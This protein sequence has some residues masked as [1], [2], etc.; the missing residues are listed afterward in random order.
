VF[1]RAGWQVG[2]RYLTALFPFLLPLVAVAL[3]AWRADARKLGLAGGAIGIGV[4]VYAVSAATLP[5]W[6]DLYQDP[7]YEVAFRL[8]G[9]GAA[10]PSLG[11]ALGLPRIVAI[12]PWLGLVIAVTA[13]AI[14]R[15]GGLRALAISAGITA[16]GIGAFALVPHGGAEPERAYVQTVY[17]LVMQR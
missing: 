16:A 15:A 1:W 3:A 4:V 14:A 2:P 13:W 10:A 9:D 5:S 12:A 11:S 7:L 17:P 6:P 8:L